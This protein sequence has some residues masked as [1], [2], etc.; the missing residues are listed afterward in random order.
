MAGEQQNQVNIALRYAGTSLGTLFTLLGAVQFIS[1]EQVAQLASA[2]HD[3]SASIITGYGALLKM[4]V[5][6]GPLAVG[7]LTALG[8][9]SGAA[10]A[11]GAKLLDMATAVKNSADTPAEARLAIAN[12]ADAKQVLIAATIAL[13]EV[14]TIVTDSATAA[15]APSNSVVPETSVKI[16]K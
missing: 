4:W 3:L 6:L 7:G 11:M 1:P 5:I 14:K 10:K 13:P 9:K 16:V 2:S 8:I 12:A 15:A